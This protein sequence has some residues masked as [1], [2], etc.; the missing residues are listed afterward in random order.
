LAQANFEPTFSCINT[1]TIPKPSY[2]SSY[3]PAYEDGT[4]R[5]FRK[6]G[7]QNS[8]ARELPRRKHTKFKVTFSVSWC[9]SPSGPE[10]SRYRGFKITSD[11]PQS[12]GLSGRVISPSQRHLPD[13]KQHSQQT[14]IYVPYRV[15]TLNPSK[16]TTADPRLRPRDHWDRLQRHTDLFIYKVE[17]NTHMKLVRAAIAQSI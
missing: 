3:L 10:P 1:L 2:Y 12:V 15:R 14:T 11:A 13:N 5:V 16:R 8:E 4:D 6:V 17:F 9:N 7:I